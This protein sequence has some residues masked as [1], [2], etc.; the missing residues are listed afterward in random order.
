MDIEVHKLVDGYVNSSV[1]SISDETILAIGK[2]YF[3]LASGKEPVKETATPKEKTV[4]VI[5]AAY[6]IKEYCSKRLCPGCPFSYLTTSDDLLYKCCLHQE[7]GYP[8]AKWSLPP[9][10]V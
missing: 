10:E 1:V 6:I 9:K 5:E 8:P 7:Y 3:E 2:Q 4:D